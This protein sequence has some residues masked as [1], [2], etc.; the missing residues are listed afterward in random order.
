M[1]A[2]LLLRLLEYFA[3]II[4]VLALLFVLME[5]A[6][7]FDRLKQR[8]Y[9][10]MALGSFLL[11]LWAL[12]RAMGLNAGVLQLTFGIVQISGFFLLGAGYLTLHHQEGDEF[13]T[14]PPTVTD[15]KSIT[16]SKESWVA[17]LTGEGK[18]IESTA[19]GKAK[20]ALT[21]E[22]DDDKVVQKET[23][24]TETTP[25]KMAGVEEAEKVQ[26]SEVSTSTPVEETVETK[27]KPIPAHGTV[28]LSYLGSRKR[29]QKESKA[30]A[31]KIDTP[32]APDMTKK[33]PEQSTEHKAE[34]PKPTVEKPPQ[35]RDELL[36]D[37]FPLESKTKDHEPEVTLLPGEL[38]LSKD[39][40]SKTDS[41]MAAVGLAGLLGNQELLMLW[42]QAA[43]VLVVFFIIMELIPYRKIRGNSLLLGGFAVLFGAYI[44]QAYT[45]QQ[46]RPL[47][48]II[49][50]ILEVIGF[51]CLG[52]A[53]WL[54][55]KGKI[56]HH[57]LTIVS[58]FYLILLSLAI[59]TATI[60]TR[61]MN[62]LS[63][64][65]NLTTGLLIVALPILHGVAYSHG[66]TDTNEGHHER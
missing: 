48:I 10:T 34:E 64:L 52:G 42:P 26:A 22:P 15:P 28:D 17:L 38:R 32:V 58:V 2:E 5:A 54:K 40:P 16:D 20:G 12:M 41:K 13:E 61:D 4:I 51:A 45:S 7:K 60:I 9:L 24:V 18:P 19:Q 11:I 23:V 39:H 43:V 46:A 53:S 35:T 27:V 37:L 14:V 44:F 33:S 57:F 3:G 55:I 31:I 8:S 66:K 59:I 36:D 49:G 30:P 6:R 50:L 29:S 62:S 63:L 47:M 1:S 21:P 56:T 25:K 65:L